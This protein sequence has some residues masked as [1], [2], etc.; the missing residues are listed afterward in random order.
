ML[1]PRLASAGGRVARNGGCLGLWP[2]CARGAA[3]GPAPR[4]AVLRGRHLRRLP[5]PNVVRRRQRAQGD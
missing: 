2:L 4:A 1:T 5:R 3:A